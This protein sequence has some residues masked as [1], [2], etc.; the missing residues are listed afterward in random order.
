MT[1]QQLI[2][3]GVE[4]QLL[5][6]RFVFVLENMDKHELATQNL[7]FRQLALL[8]AYN[9][10]TVWRVKPI[11]NHLPQRRRPTQD[12]FL[13][14]EQVSVSQ[15]QGGFC[16]IQPKNLSHR[17]TGSLRREPKW[18]KLRL[19][20][21]NT[22]PQWGSPY[23]EVINWDPEP[24][25]QQ[26]LVQW[27]SHK[28]PSRGMF[29]KEV[30]NLSHREPFCKKLQLPKEPWQW[31]KGTIFMGRELL[32]VQASS[33]DFVARVGSPSWSGPSFL[34]SFISS[35]HPTLVVELQVSKLLELLSKCAFP[36][37]WNPLPALTQPDVS[38]Q[39]PQLLL[40]EP[41]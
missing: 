41:T 39:V 36:D 37:A 40:Q 23:S 21:D 11:K 22:L 5:E 6:T 34:S 19:P 9:V 13:A 30:K 33:L 7:Y 18:K 14:Q 1:L 35:S 3:L 26:T 31:H 10:S 28:T 17:V 20:D 2:C 32:S 4:T 27:Q 29:V 25:K 16:C 38:W 12:C 8:Q 24:R 15:G